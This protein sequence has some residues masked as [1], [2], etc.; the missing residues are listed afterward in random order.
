MILLLPISRFKVQYQVGRGRSFSV[1]DKDILGFVNDGVDT[2]EELESILCVHPSVILQSLLNLTHAG[3]LAVGVGDGSRFN[4]TRSGKISAESKSKP[5]TAVYEE[6]FQSL[7]LDGL[8]SQVSSTRDIRYLNESKLNSLS[9]LGKK[10]VSRINTPRLST[11]DVNNFLFRRESEWLSSIQ[12]VSLISRN[13]D[14]VPIEFDRSSLRLSKNIPWHW[15]EVLEP[16]IFW[17]LRK[18]GLIA[19]DISYSEFQGSQIDVSTGPET[20][21]R[22]GTPRSPDRKMSTYINYDDFLTTNIDHE[23]YF[24]RSLIRAKKNIIVCSAFLRAELVAQYDD[25]IFDCLDRGVNIDFLWGYNAG[26]GSEGDEG[27][28]ELQKISFTAKSKGMS[29]VLNFNLNRTNSHSKLILYDSEHGVEMCIGSYNWLSARPDFRSMERLSNLSVVVRD[30]LLISRLMRCISSLWLSEGQGLRGMSRRWENLAKGL[31][32][33][34]LENL[35]NHDGGEMCEVSLLLDDDHG[36]WFSAA[37]ISARRRFLTLSHRLGPAAFGRARVEDTI[38]LESDNPVAKR[39]VYSESDMEE[40]LSAEFL[41]R[42]TGRGWLFVEK[43][44]MHSKLAISDDQMCIGSFNF[45]STDVYDRSKSGKEISVVVKS[46]ELSS[47]FARYVLDE[48]FSE[49]QEIDE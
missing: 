21:E 20:E 10:L 17:F 29:G 11:L 44:G 46:E 24:R 25:L 9:G 8:T 47:H 14:W 28:R 40:E 36:P 38:G 48:F 15:R 49:T 39:L 32:R 41:G 33:S 13:R 35:N 22:R 19:A 2:L 43:K 31:E 4:L 1:F 6:R 34:G 45:M 23:K 3:W 12:N 30:R 7:V 18:E 37:H 27:V 26:L 42:L 5:R 16:E